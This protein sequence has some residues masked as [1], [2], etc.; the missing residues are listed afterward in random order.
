MAPASGGS[1]PH[2]QIHSVCR[3][4]ASMRSTIYNGID[5]FSPHRMAYSVDRQ[6]ALEV[7]SDLPT[8]A[9]ADPPTRPWS[10]LIVLNCWS[11]P[12]AA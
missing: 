10:C 2:A 3:L 5:E 9:T 7:G 8:A 4:V 11:T 12:S 6:L 1:S